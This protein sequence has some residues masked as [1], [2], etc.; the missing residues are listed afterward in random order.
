VHPGEE[1]IHGVAAAETGE[2]LLQAHA[3]QL[4]GAKDAVD[5]D[6]IAD[7]EPAARG[8]GIVIGEFVAHR[9]HPHLQRIHP[10][11]PE[12]R[13]PADDRQRW[14][15]RCERRD[16]RRRRDLEAPAQERNGDG[17]DQTRHSRALDDI[18]HG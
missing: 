18:T 1:A 11:V 6:R 14:R 4:P 15:S 17:R 16:G 12:A 7:P 2:C 3:R 10:G 5:P 9:E 8:L 13:A